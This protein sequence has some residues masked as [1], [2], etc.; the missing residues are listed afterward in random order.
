MK[1]TPFTGKIG[2]G[3][4]VSFLLEKGFEIVEK[5][6]RS[7]K[8]GEIDIIAY[9]SQVL[10]FLEVKTRYSEEYGQPIEAIGISKQRQIARMAKRYLYDKELYGKVDCRFDVISIK[11]DQGAKVIEHIEDA[12]RVNPK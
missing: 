2:E 4:A 3:M 11:L 1:E 10:V 7:G 8:D 12:F 5:N 6:W 9:D